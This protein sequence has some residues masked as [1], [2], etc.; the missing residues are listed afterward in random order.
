MPFTSASTLAPGFFGKVSTHGDFVSRRLSVPFV[1]GWDDWL[2]RGM[3]ASRG[4]LGSAW[5]ETY[6]TSPIWRF[7]MSAGILDDHAWAGIIMPNVDRVGRHFPLTIAAGLP[8][9]TDLLRWQA[10]EQGW[11]DDLEQ[12]ALSSLEATFMLDEFDRALQYTSMLPTS[13]STLSNLESEQGTPLPWYLPMTETDQFNVREA[14]GSA[15]ILTNLLKGHSLW[16][17]DGS[18][19]IQPCA[20]ICEGLPSSLQCIAML[21]GKWA[22]AGWQSPAHN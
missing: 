9:T 1:Q 7:A 5:L 2:Q 19:H 21:D 18:P 13:R 22:Q 14:L 12:L 20:L 4:A 3:H 11:Y 15:D 17:T 8:A 10:N 16:W 6:L